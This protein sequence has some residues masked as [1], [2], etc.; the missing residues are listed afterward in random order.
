[1]VETGTVGRCS[2]N[3]GTTIAQNFVSTVIQTE[4][5]TSLIRRLNDETS[6]RF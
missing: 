4:P 3:S 6:W 1:M 2:T 5:S